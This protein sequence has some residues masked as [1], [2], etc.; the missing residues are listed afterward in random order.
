M[1]R[2]KR[3]N[4]VSAALVSYGFLFSVH[5]AMAYVLIESG[6]GGMEMAR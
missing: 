2:L 5:M 3:A 6:E 1:G 4:E